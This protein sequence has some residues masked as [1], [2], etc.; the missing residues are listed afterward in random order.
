MSKITLIESYTIQGAISANIESDTVFILSNERIKKD[1][2]VGRYYT[3]FPSFKSFLSVREMYKHCHEIL[4]DH[5]NNKK[6]PSGRLVFDFDIKSEYIP[7]DFKN[8]IENTVYEVVNTY[9]KNI[10]TDK[11]KFIWSTSENPKKFSKHLTVKNMCFDNWILMSSSFY[12]LFCEIW[13]RTYTWIES[14]NLIDFQ[15]IK[16]NTSLRMVGSSK[17]NG[18]ILKFDDPSDK[19]EDSLIR[20]YLS[21]Q[22]K[23]EQ[24]VTKNNFISSVF[25]NILKPIAKKFYYHGL[26]YEEPQYFFDDDV[27]RMA[28]LSFDKV[29]PNV[30]R[31]RKSDNG[32]IQLLR[33]KSSKC[34]LCK[35]IHDSENAWLRVLLDD[36]MYTVHFHCYR[37]YEKQSLYIGSL[38]VNNLIFFP[39]PNLKQNTARNVNNNLNI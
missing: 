16:K 3:V 19:L 6:N 25:D 11:F 32:K 30:F 20:V 24:M 18:N 28:Y 13:D 36:E 31:V 27:Y 15:I 4:L 21:R 1:K 26:N 37:N 22:R 2:S 14:K 12:K 9:M 7:H 29:C 34:I 23:I 5:E 38:S 8:Q 39:N 10:D 33:K 35:K 17:I